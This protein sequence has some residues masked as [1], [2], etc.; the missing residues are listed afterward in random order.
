[1]KRKITVATNLRVYGASKNGQKMQFH[2]T[3]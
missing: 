3:Y 2:K 1:M